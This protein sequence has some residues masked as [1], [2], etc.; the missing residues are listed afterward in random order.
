MTHCREGFIPLRRD[1]LVDWLC[2]DCALT[3]EERDLFGRFCRQL[4]AACH[5]RF[6]RRFEELKGAY[7]PFDPDSD[8]QSLFRLSA[9]ERQKRLND[10]YR[11]FAWLMDRANF[12]HLS[13]ED[14]EP[15]LREA[16]D[17]GVHMRV[18]FSAFEHLAIFARG[19][20]LLPRKRRRLRRLYRE[21]E[22]TVPIYRRL[23][24]ILKIR[25]DHDY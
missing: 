21:E 17:W 16:S 6:N 10:L 2:A 1:E 25:P 22:T 20:A 24:M 23:V 15:T 18:D 11:D 3:S 8:L 9:A 7:A 5:L 14:I 12:V 4:A 19:D 13:R